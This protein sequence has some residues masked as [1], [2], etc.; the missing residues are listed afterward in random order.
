M[1]N[2]AEIGRCRAL[3]HRLTSPIVLGLL[4]A[5]IIAV[6][7]VPF[8]PAASAQT[9]TFGPYELVARHS[10]KCLDVANA[11]EAHG[12]DVIQGNCSHRWNQQFYLRPSGNGYMIVARHSNKC[13]DV[14]NFSRRHLAN[15]LQASCRGTSNQRW[16]F[17]S[18]SGEGKAND[19]SDAPPRVGT[20]YKM[21]PLHV[22][23]MCLDVANLSIAHAANVIQGSC[24]N[25]GHNQ[26]WTLVAVRD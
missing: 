21:R 22:R 24:W 20:F 8:A 26:Q 9:Q 14:E 6:A 13:V 3:R 12:A 10:N 2:F 17:F 1:C 19:I 25:P 11:S 16:R 15:V 23:N 18:V 4:L 5:L 7:S